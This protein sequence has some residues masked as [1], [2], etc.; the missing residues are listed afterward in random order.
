MA[1]LAQTPGNS[2]RQ[3]QGR[4]G[5]ANLN[6]NNSN[7]LAAKRSCPAA[8]D[9]SG[10][11][12]NPLKVKPSYQSCKDC[13]RLP[14]ARRCD[15]PAGG[16]SHR[17]NS[18]RHCNVPP[19]YIHPPGSTF[20]PS[21]ALSSMATGVVTPN[22]IYPCTH[23]C[24]TCTT[25]VPS[26][27]RPK[28][29]SPMS[30]EDNMSEEVQGH[31]QAPTDAINASTGMAPPCASAVPLQMQIPTLGMGF[32]LDLMQQRAEQLEKLPSLAVEGQ[33]PVGPLP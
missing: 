4:L 24:P 28:L 2:D 20:S 17:L 32:G 21:P 13:L 7:R 6:T 23:F 16:R 8:F 25:G 26:A 3:E 14:Q 1:A 31:V 5:F 22:L 18:S 12:S 15:R 19:I 9:D 29:S 27:H 30:C 10:S 33:L 11:S